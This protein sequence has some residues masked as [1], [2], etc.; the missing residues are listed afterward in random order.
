MQTNYDIIII[1]A[2][3]V[4]LS[5]AHALADSELS[6]AIVEAKA[7]E[8]VWPRDGYDLRVSAINPHSQQFF[9]QLNLWQAIKAL[10][11]S[12]FEKMYVWDANSDGNITFDAADDAKP[13]LG[14]IIENSV[15]RK[16]MLDVLPSN[17]TLLSPITLTAYQPKQLTTATGE[18]LHANVIV[19]ADGGNSWLRQQ[20]NIAITEHDYQA[21]AIVA[22]VKT[23]KPH[24]CMA[25][26]R[27]LTT[28]P[29]AF[30]PLDDSN[31]CS[32]VWSAKNEEVERLMA[33]TDTEFEQ[34]ITHA[35]ENKLG[36]V[37]LQSARPSFPLIAKHAKHYVDEG[38]A[39]IGDAA[40]TIHP[41]AGL[42]VNLG[43][44]DAKCLADTINTAL[45]SDRNHAAKQV[46][47][48]YERARKADNVITQKTM[49]A[50]DKLFSSNNA[51]ATLRGSGLNL[52]D[53]CQVLKT[54]FTQVI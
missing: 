12:P 1:G 29:L 8:P 3:M 9:E 15:I 34:A 6:I 47:R 51:L 5:L 17:V 24:Q 13:Y 42:G 14:H 7:D 19:G 48:K 38:L 33:L 35:F 10:R 20:A 41:L 37:S 36:N 39:L 43:F 40:H 32:I 11:I 4:G 46:L 21:R 53:K 18:T 31:Y 45:Q 52:T 16:T 49:T 28:G 50:F 26:Q 22:T 25:Y 30:L 44:A 2:G 54:A 27:F 23:E